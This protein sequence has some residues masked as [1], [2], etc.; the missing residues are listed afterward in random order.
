MRTPQ[1]SGV[2]IHRY[3]HDYDISPELVWRCGSAG[4]GATGRAAHGRSYRHAVGSAAY[5]AVS[6]VPDLQHITGVKSGGDFGPPS[7]CRRSS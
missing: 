1:F 3:M 2:K 7:Q 5:A 6:L 4:F